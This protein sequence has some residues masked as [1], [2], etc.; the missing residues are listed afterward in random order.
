MF[1]LQLLYRGLSVILLYATVLCIGGCNGSATYNHTGKNDEN[2]KINRMT[3]LTTWINQ[4]D[5]HKQTHLLE[6]L[7]NKTCPVKVI[8]NDINTCLCT[9]EVCAKI[10]CIGS[11]KGSHLSINCKI[12][13]VLVNHVDCSVFVVIDDLSYGPIRKYICTSCSRKMFSIEE[14]RLQGIVLSDWDT[15]TTVNLGER[16]DMKSHEGVFDA[17]R[18]CSDNADIAAFFTMRKS[19]LYFCVT[20]NCKNLCIISK[21][22]VRIQSSQKTIWHSVFSK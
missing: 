20:G 8:R 21:G 2:Q 22:K 15:L 11:E 7:N 10:E 16:D 19:V 14:I 13:M 18:D 12:E 3:F 17:F 5:N 1:T 4:T 9:T 6:Y